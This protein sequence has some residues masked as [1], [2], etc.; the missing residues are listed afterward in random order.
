MSK[1]RSEFPALAGE[2]I[3][4]D[5]AGGSQTLGTVIEA[6]RDYLS[7]TNVQLGATYKTG[8]LATERYDAGFAAGARYVNAA[9]SEIAFGAST[10]QLFRNVSFALEFAEGD[11]IVISSIDHEANIAPWLDLARRQKL[12]I[13][14]WTPEV[15]FLPP[16]SSSNPNPNPNPQPLPSNLTPLLTSRTRLVTCTHVSN[17]LGSIHPIAA[18]AAA[19]R[20]GPSPDALVVVDGVSYAP[21]RALDV[22]ALDVDVYAF[23]WYKVYGPHIAMLYASPRAQGQMRSLGHFFKKGDTLEEKVGLAG[24]S[25]ELLH[26]IPAVTNYLIPSSSSSSSPF[27]VDAAAH[28][29]VLQTRLLQYLTGRPDVT[30]YGDVTGSS[31]ARVATVSFRVAGWPSRDVVAA[32]ETKADI[33]FR[34]GGFYSERLV[35][36]LL[37]LDEDG[38]V[39]V[40]LV[41]YNTED[42]VKK[43]IHA[44][45]TYVPKKA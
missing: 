17:V 26:S 44:M 36:D 19:V 32:I 34:W 6:I 11:E 16:S 37:G 22:R 33:G 5:N 27:W 8:K 4:F 45:E 9:T 13:K 38:V 28:E 23:S 2:Q 25:Y 40:S 39:R 14:W 12:V 1:F 7:R 43:F 31:E 30:V 42:E 10:T 29:E 20:A 21:H 15:T 24:A 41:H 18:I 35:R 3:F